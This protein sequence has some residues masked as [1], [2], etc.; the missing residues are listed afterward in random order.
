MEHKYM[1]SEAICEFIVSTR[2]AGK[3]IRFSEQYI[4][5]RPCAF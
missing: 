5:L 1:Y 3:L 4:L 2:P